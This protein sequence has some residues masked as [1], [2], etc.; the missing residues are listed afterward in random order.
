M[1]LLSDRLKAIAS[2]IPESNVVADIGC[3]HAYIAIHLVETHKATKVIGCDVNKGPL[4]RAHENAKSYGVENQIELRLSDGLEQ[5]GKGEADCIVI[6]GMGGPLMQRIITEGLDKLCENTQLILQPQSDIG[7]FRRF[8]KDNGFAV[9]AE[10][11]VFEDGKYYP[12]MRVQKGEMDWIDD[13]DFEYGYFLLR[14][15]DPVLKQYLMYEKGLLESIL[16]NFIKGEMSERSE[17]RKREIKDRIILNEK[18]GRY[19]NEM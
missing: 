17:S 18:A 19:I 13:I 12:M 16:E 10:S 8:L 15:G 6:A 5:I 3:D 9:T 2:L 11:M 1:I 14:A 7:A 4:L